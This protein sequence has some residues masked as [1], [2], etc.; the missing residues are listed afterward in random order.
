[1]P[2]SDRH[3]AW[4]VMSRERILDASPWLEVWQEAVELP[5]GR[6]VEGYHVVEAPD[7]SIVVAFTGDGRVVVERHY[8]HA[9]R[10]AVLDLPAGRIEPEEEPLS[11]AQR[12][13]LEETGYGGGEWRSLGA[14]S[15][16]VSRIRARG[17]VFVARGVEPQG[18]PGSDDL[19]DTEVLLLTPDE[20]LAAIGRGEVLDASGVAAFLL[21]Q[22]TDG[23]E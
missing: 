14:Y 6:I 10:R 11:G 20:L 18:E 21:A 12:E 7:F 8:R 22:A 13:L 1:M 16:S 23:R 3:A 5:D 9:A 4:R 2:D 15:L 19:E 17:H